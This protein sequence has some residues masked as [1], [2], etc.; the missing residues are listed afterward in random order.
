MTATDITFKNRN[1][2]ILSEI[3]SFDTA[4]RYDLASS[5]M[6]FGGTTNILEIYTGSDAVINVRSINTLGQAFAGDENRVGINTNNPG[7][8][9]DVA[10]TIRATSYQNLTLTDFPLVMPSKGGTGLTQLG[11]PEQI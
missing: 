3:S 2:K 10:G 4:I 5:T 8:T 6:R 1:L 7:A 9:L 11:Q